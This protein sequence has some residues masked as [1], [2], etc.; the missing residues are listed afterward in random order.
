MT[1]THCFIN[2]HVESTLSTEPDFKAADAAWTFLQKHPDD[3]EMKQ[4]LE[5]YKWKYPEVDRRIRKKE[6]QNLEVPLYNRH[7]I[8]G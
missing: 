6:L 1:V 7:F 4:N 8:N 2:R 3:E 5:Y